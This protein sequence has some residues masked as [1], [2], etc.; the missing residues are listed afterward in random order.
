LGKHEADDEI[1]V[2][3]IG[4]GLLLTADQAQADE[5][6]KEEKHAGYQSDI[7]D[8]VFYQSRLTHALLNFKSVKILY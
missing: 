1:A 3:G 5:S 8:D 2:N 7:R 6:H 4:I